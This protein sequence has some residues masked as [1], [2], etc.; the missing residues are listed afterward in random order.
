MD[1]PKVVLCALEAA[2]TVQSHSRLSAGARRAGVAC[3]ATGGVW[4][5]LVATGWQPSGCRSH[6]PGVVE[7]PEPHRSDRKVRPV[8]SV[9]ETAG[10]DEYVRWCG[11]TGAV[12]PPPTP[13]LV[14]RAGRCHNLARAPAAASQHRQE[15]SQPVQQEKRRCHQGLI[16][17]VHCRSDD[18]AEDKGNHHPIAEEAD[19]APGGDDAKP[20]PT[21]T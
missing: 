3:L 19:Q 14:D 21:G 10:Y 6:E 8:E 20:G 7:E 5:R 9:Q 18:G 17:R 1:S 15:N 4:Q 13:I 16:H 12:R 11:R 2:E